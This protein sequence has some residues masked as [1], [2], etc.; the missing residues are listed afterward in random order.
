MIDGEHIPPHVGSTD[1]DR[2]YDRPVIFVDADNTLWDTDRVFADA[3]LELLRSVEDACKTQA[4]TSDRLDFIRTIDQE[5]ADR[6]HLGLRY[7]PRLLILAL[8]LMLQGISPKEAAKKA[9]IGVIDNNA[10]SDQVFEVIQSRYFENLGKMPPLMPGVK[11]GLSELN[12][13]SARILVLTEG[14]KDRVVRTAHSLG[15][16]QFIDKVIEAKKDRRLFERVLRL[17]GNPQIAVMVGDQV[18]RDITPA[19][20]AGLHTIYIPGGFKPRWE[21]TE[22]KYLVDFQLDSFAE[23]PKIIERLSRDVEVSAP[24]KGR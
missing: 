10:I 12:A 18:T 23:A 15:I 20:Q 14:R 3:Q 5:L 7:P 1:L 17:V 21:E 2:S 24:T 4:D 6:H 9:W 8:S 22:S 13:S 16:M 19:S 11:V